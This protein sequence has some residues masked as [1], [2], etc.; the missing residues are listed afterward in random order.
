MSNP[1]DSNA[2]RPT[3]SIVEV[4]SNDPS[5]TH[6]TQQSPS[7]D[8]EY[9]KT[10]KY[11]TEENATTDELSKEISEY[12]N[13]QL[14]ANT[15]TTTTNPKSHLSY[16]QRFKLKF[17]WYKIAFQIFL[18]CFFTS[19]WLSIVIQKKHRH[20]WLIPTVLWGDDYGSFNN[21]ALSDITL[22]FKTS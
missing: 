9:N 3:S 15:N 5:H 12:D 8:L 7:S 21:M 18:G 14:E 1:Y 20:Q 11:I 17:P 19:W 13:A 22:V 10:E 4:N 16:W 6:K 2:I